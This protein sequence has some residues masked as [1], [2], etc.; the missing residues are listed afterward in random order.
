MVVFYTA[1]VKSANI[2]GPLGVGAPVA[3]IGGIGEIGLE[4]CRALALN[5]VAAVA[6]DRDSPEVGER[7]L[8]TSGVKATYRQADATDRKQLSDT[9]SSIAGLMGA[10]ANAGVVDSA[11]FLDAS[12]APSAPDVPASFKGA[13]NTA[14]AAARLFAESGV[15]GRIVFVTSWLQA[16]ATINPSH[17]R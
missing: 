15:R 14:Q 6:I 5:G 12:D 9:L 2:R 16:R 17:H 13:L 10:V 11:P 8:S 3:V 4:I 7:K 1:M